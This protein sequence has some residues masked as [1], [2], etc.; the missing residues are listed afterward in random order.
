MTEA[1]FTDDE[2]L[3]ALLDGALSPDD[4][5]RLEQ[6][7]E[8]EPVLR[9]RFEALQRA[10]AMVREAYA[11]VVGEPLPKE[12]LDLL[13][14]ENATAGNVVPLAGR[15]R[16]THSRFVGPT[17]LAASIALALGIALGIVVAPDRQ[18]F[19]AV[20]LAAQVGAV[21]PGSALFEVLEEVPSAETRELAAG[22]TATPVLTFG[23]AGGGYCREVDVEASEGTTQM[24]A[25]RRNGAWRLAHTS[26]VVSAA[27]NGVFRP[28]SGP[29]PAIDAAI[30]DLIAGAPLDGAAERALISNGW[31]DAAR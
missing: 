9:A 28:A 1:R 26:Y 22:V 27:T 14:A 13:A 21:A 19:D 12:L 6:R 8:R 20:E 10:N 3:S 2:L 16:R 4:A 24:L 30:D 29:S 5:A 23:T 18:P 31:S 7:L 17:A 11:G 15:Q 25:C